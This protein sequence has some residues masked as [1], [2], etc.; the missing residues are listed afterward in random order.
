MVKVPG[1]TRPDH[2]KRRRGLTVILIDTFLMW[3]GFFMGTAME[4]GTV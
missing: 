1:P 3:G 2:R 4:S